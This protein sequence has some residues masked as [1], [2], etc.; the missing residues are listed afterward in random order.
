MGVHKRSPLRRMVLDGLLL[1][2]VAALLT[3]TIV[4]VRVKLLQNAQSLGMALARSYAVEEQTH[5]HN[6]EVNLVMAWHYVDEILDDGGSTQD[7]QDWLEDCFANL[8]SIIGEGMVDFYAVIDGQI[9]AA[10]PWEGDASFDYLSAPWYRQALE[11]AGEPVCSQS[12]LDA[13][14]GQPVITLA[15]AL[16][17][18]GNVLAMDVYIANPSLHLITQDMPEDFS[19]YLCG[20]DGRLLYAAVP[21]KTQPEQ[22]ESFASYLFAG[23]SDGSLLAYDASVVGLDGAARGVYYCPMS[24]GWTAILTIPMRAIL[25]GEQNATVSLVAGAALALYV[26][27]I[28]LT[29]QDVLRVRRVKAADDT[30][31]MLGD[32]F[33]AIYRVNFRDGRYQTVKAHQSASALP[34]TG[35]YGQ[36]LHH[37]SSF[38]QPSALKAFEDS[39]SL[40]SIRRRTSQNIAD[41]GG[42]YQRLFGQTYRWANIRTLFNRD[43][44]PNVVILCFRDVDEEKRRELQHTLLLQDALEAAKKSTRAKSNFFSSMSHDMRTPL[45]AILGCCDLAQHSCREGNLDKIQEY[46]KKIAFSG[47]QLLGLINDILEVSRMEAGK[48]NL[49][50]RELN[51]RRLLANLADIFRD[52]LEQAGKSLQVSVDFED[53]VVIGDE[54]KIA[55][56]VNNLLSNAVKYTGPGGHVSLEA[57]QFR[58]RQHSKYQIQVADDGIGMSP[59][60]LEHLFDPYSRETAFTPSPVGGTGLG[61]TIVHGL[62][63]Q[64]SGEISVESQLGQGSR[65]VVT[66]PLQAAPRGA[67]PAVEERDGE[68]PSF[69]WQG[70]RVLVAEDNALNREILAAFLGRF[71]AQTLAAA[72]GEEAVRLFQAQPPFSVDAI[73]MDMQMPRM[74]G[75]QAAA[76]I[77]RLDRADAACVPIVAVTANAFAEDIS[78]TT[79]A[80]MDAHISK[81]VDAAVLRQTVEKLI[82]EREGPSHQEDGP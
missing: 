53:D 46:L 74:D 32:S 81:P 24:N 4:L 82:L 9:V 2:F 40:E 49:E 33:Y 1:V 68:A 78:R 55:Q 63:G 51:L 10:N 61:M 7:I 13:V 11:A 41:Y 71:G 59:E 8:S 43:V 34:V 23:V 5:L 54:K 17:G 21:W 37:I 6:L 19:Y 76:A 22:L 57:R 25:M 39:F 69:R 18:S 3:L 12:Y 47:D 38:V 20:Q 62:V 64:M 26:A 42:D 50:Q 65:F 27:L 80:G 31:H 30:V 44:D 75:C 35:D 70:R 60:F 16:S 52:Q 28:F 67:A 58:F 56:I 77:R 79:A 72:D 48:N 73:L 29:V 36:L 15:Q 66:L 45:N 14:T